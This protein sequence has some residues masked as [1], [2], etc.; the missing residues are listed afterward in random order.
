LQKNLSSQLLMPT[1]INNTLSF[2]FFF[3]FVVPQYLLLSCS[4]VRQIMAP[5][6]IHFPLSGVHRSCRNPLPIDTKHENSNCSIFRH[7]GKHSTSYTPF[8][9][10]LKSCITLTSASIFATKEDLY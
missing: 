1:G 8:S 6:S 4:L 5:F 3:H 2:I 7:T 10:K 9:R